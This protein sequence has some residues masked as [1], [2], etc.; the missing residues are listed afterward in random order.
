MRGGLDQVAFGDVDQ[1]ANIV[2]NPC[3]IRLKE[4]GVRVLVCA[5]GDGRRARGRLG[6]A[7]RLARKMRRLSGNADGSKSVYEKC[8]TA[9]PGCVGLP[10]NG[11]SL[12]VF[13]GRGRLCHPPRRAER[14][15]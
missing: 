1:A 2:N 8:G 6:R 3:A 4:Y 12:A 5:W 15:F 7:G 11:W 14:S 10:N 9:A 13:H